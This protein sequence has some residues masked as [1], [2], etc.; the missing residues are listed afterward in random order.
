MREA[1]SITKDSLL[2]DNIVSSALKGLEIY[3]S[4][5]VGTIFL[6]ENKIVFMYKEKKALIFSIH[7]KSAFHSPGEIYLNG[8]LFCSFDIEEDYNEHFSTDEIVCNFH[9]DE[10][11][12][13]KLLIK[14]I[15]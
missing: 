6:A 9:N 3:E 1:P 2:L 8:N 14:D 4:F 7:F 11:E 12:V 5:K 15:L 13:Y 10:S